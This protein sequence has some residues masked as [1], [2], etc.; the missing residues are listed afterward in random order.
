MLKTQMMLSSTMMN[1]PIVVVCNDAGDDG[2]D[3]VD[4]YYFH[5][6]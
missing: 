3:D 4:A 6:Q 1:D 5:W 2:C